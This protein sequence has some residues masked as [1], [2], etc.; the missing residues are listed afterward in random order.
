MNKED[1]RNLTKSKFSELLKSE[2]FP[3]YKIKQ[4]YDWLWVKGASSFSEMT[5]ISKEIREWLDS[6]YVI[7]HAIIN[8]IYT[9]IDT[10]IKVAFRLHDSRLVEGVIIPSGDRV[11]ACVSSQTGC[12]LDCAFCATGKITD[13]RNLTSGE[14]FDQ[15]ILLNKLSLERY[16]IKLTNIVMMGMGEPLLNL[17]SVKRAIVEFT[18]PEGINFS[19]TRI[20]ISTVGISKNIKAL[21]DLNLNVNLAVSLHS[22]IEQKRK[23]IIPYSKSDSLSRLSEAIKYFHEKT[24]NRPTIEYLLLKKFN[25]SIID[26]EELAKFCRSFPCK[27]NLIEYNSTDDS[28]FSKSTNESLN[29]FKEFLESKNMVVNVRISRGSDINAACGQLVNKNL[30]KKLTEK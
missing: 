2:N 30:N 10:T 25:D 12:G 1:I 11:T 9:S 3:S 29:M 19:P 7:N 28:R 6:K 14:I 27:V 4:I 5:N 24:H 21:A 18:S 26:A 20:T 15:F 22:A 17:E 13:F 8:D 16:G 23:S